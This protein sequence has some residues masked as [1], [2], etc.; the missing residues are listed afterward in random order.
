MVQSTEILA[1]SNECFFVSEIFA[2]STAQDE[3]VV[4]ICGED[5]QRIMQ[6]CVRD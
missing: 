1:M 6:R 4:N 2:R 5:V 3:I